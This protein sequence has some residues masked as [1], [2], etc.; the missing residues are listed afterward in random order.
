MHH[1]KGQILRIIQKKVEMVMDLKR[2]KSISV[3]TSMSI[4]ERKCLLSWQEF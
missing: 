3:P 2:L 4:L 1:I